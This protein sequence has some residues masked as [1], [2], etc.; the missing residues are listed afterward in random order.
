MLA[1]VNFN[2]QEGM[3]FYLKEMFLN[4]FLNISFFFVFLQFMKKAKIILG[5]VAVTMLSVGCNRF[6][7]LLNSNDYDKKYEAA[8]KYYNNNIY[9]R[10]AQLFENLTLYYRG[11]ENAENIAWYYGMSLYKEKD[12]YTAGYQFKRFARQFPYSDRLEDA[13]FYSAYCKYM[14]SPEYNLDQSET[15]ESI[16]EFEAFVEHWPHSTRIPEVNNCLD[17]MRNKLIRKSY[18]I[19][20]GYYFIEEYHAAYESFKQFL[21]LYPEAKQREDAMYYMLESSY[22]YAINSREDKMYERLQ[23][24][25][26]DFDKFSSSFGDS[27]RLADAQDI[28]TKTRAKMAEIKNQKQ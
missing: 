24:V 26:N 13:C 5:I 9:S 22:L 16:E 7:K 18:E 2:T 12:Y 14:D 1:S 8:M 20:Y 10:A 6:N 3:D 17:E 28:Y 21:S 27:K 15:K 19:S 25:V 4:L 23:Q 11:K